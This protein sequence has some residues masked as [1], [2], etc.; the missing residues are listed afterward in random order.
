MIKETLFYKF[1]AQNYS[2]DNFCNDI[3]SSEMK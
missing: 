2:Y 1:M 3:K